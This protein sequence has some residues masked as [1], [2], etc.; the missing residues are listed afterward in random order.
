MGYSAIRTALIG[1]VVC[2]GAF[3]GMSASAL[4]APTPAPNT[5]A[6]TK[7]QH[8][9]TYRGYVRSYYF[10]RQNASNSTQGGANTQ[11]NQA[12]FNSAVSLHGDY[13]FA[14]TPWS[15]G[16][17][18]L[19]ADPLNSCS[20]ALQH[21]KGMRCVSNVAPNT[22]PDDTL[23]GFR[24]NTLYEAY[25][26]Y[27]TPDL[28]GKA[29]DQLI[30]TPWAN[31]SDSRLKPAAFQGV[32]LGGDLG[33]DW[34]LEAMD[35]IRFENRTSSSFD[36]STLLTSFPAGNP[37]IPSNTFDPGGQ[38]IHTN[39][40]ELG[41][42]AYANNT[43]LRAALYDYAV[44][45]ISNLLWLESSYSWDRPMYKPTLS[46]Q[47]GT[48]RQTGS[49]ALGK[50]SADVLGAQ[51]G[52]SPIR[53]V[54]LSFGFDSVPS[55]SDTL[56]LPAGVSCSKDAIKVS[57]GATFD[58]FL[59][60]GGSPNCEANADGTTTVYFGGIASPYTD[61]YATDP[62]FTTSLTQGMA[63]RR[64]SGSSWKVAATYVS[65]DTQFHA[66]VSRAIYDYGDAFV[67]Q[68]TAETDIDAYYYF[69][70]VGKGPYRGFLLRDRYGER[71]QSLAGLPLF[72]YN[73]TQLE[74]D[75]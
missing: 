61:G 56:V 68:H 7:P 11:V 16:G 55:K 60:S 12:S 52:A 42:L 69:N 3:V 73:R 14:E 24:L 48:E 53:N 44:S 2:A 30:T 28:F 10:T 62:L 39:G 25:V 72:K 21:V 9:F 59:P 6:G 27:K 40:F 17:S 51:L 35:M 49:A 75:F 46:L 38:S 4:S 70:R 13:R 63:D 5:A 26:Q 74:Y 54:G 50:I 64:S 32:D 41:K 65:N 1:T 58:Y 33:A 36:A 71:T 43:G 57:A 45:D 20:S 47:L 19:Y 22:N 8:A 66:I 29:G 34:S 18:Y 31:P 67:A 37:G 15:V 23:P